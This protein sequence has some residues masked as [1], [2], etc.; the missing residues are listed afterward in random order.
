[1]PAASFG[2]GYPSA[3]DPPRLATDAWPSTP[4]RHRWRG[5]GVE[6]V[7][8]RDVVLSRTYAVSGPEPVPNSRGSLVMMP[9]TPSAVREAIRSASSTVHT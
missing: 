3:G 4:T 9:S 5:Y 1:M 6:G 8:S 7:S 2:G